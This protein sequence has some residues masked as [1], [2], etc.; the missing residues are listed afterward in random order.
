MQEFLIFLKYITVVKN[1]YKSL[2][3]HRLL[4]AKRATK[5]QKMYEM[6]IWVI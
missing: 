6:V 2:I 1:R 3:L 5:A 4:R